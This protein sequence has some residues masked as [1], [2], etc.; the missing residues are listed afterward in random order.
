LASARTATRGIGRCRRPARGTHRE[1]R[2]L[3]PL[4]GVLHRISR[5]HRRE[6]HGW[7]NWLR[8]RRRVGQ[9]SAATEPA[10]SLASFRS[11]SGVLNDAIATG[12]AAGCGIE[13]GSDKAAPPLA[14]SATETPSSPSAVARGAS[15]CSAGA[16]ADVAR[17][18]SLGALVFSMPSEPRPASPA[19]TQPAKAT[20]PYK[21]ADTASRRSL[22]TPRPAKVS[23][24][25][26][27]F[28]MFSR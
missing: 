23:P 10:A 27:G 21:A 8:H 13:G 4:G 17:L 14:I 18:T 6:H 12:T 22:F 3:R 16:I 28:S 7:R 2:S 9:R 1:L 15:T 19:P 25:N 20:V 11:G 26:G 24:R 5:T